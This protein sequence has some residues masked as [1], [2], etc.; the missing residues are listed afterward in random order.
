MTGGYVVMDDALRFFDGAGRFVF[1]ARL[2]EVVKSGVY[3]QIWDKW[4]IGHA[5]L[6]DPGINLTT[7]RPIVN[8][9]P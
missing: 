3:D 7:Q 6:K 9:I 1:E 8:E 2:K 5:K 4:K